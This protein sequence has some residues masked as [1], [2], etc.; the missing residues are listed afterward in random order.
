VGGLALV[1]PVQG[2]YLLFGAVDAG[3]MVIIITH[4][5]ELASMCDEVLRLD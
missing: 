4:D 1:Q 5:R 2:V 3:G